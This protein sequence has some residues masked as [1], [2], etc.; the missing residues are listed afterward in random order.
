MF[1]EVYIDEIYTALANGSS[2]TETTG[3]T[4]RLQVRGHNQRNNPDPLARI[5]ALRVAAALGV[6]AG[7]VIA[8]AYCGDPSNDIR[9]FVL[10]QAQAAQEA[11]LPI[12]RRLTEDSDATI[13]TRALGLLRQLVDRQSV[14]L[15][16]RLLDAEHP[17]VRAAAADLL[18][19]I[20]GRSASLNLRRLTTD[21]DK[22]VF[23]AAS[24]ALKRIEG[25]LGRDKPSPWWASNATIKLP[26]P[27]TKLPKDLLARLPTP[28]PEII[29]EEA[30]QP[31]PPVAPKVDFWTTDWAAL[32]TTMPS[33]I[34]ALL[35]LLG[36]VSRE[37]RPTV[38]DALMQSA[39]DSM[40]MHINRA[41]HNNDWVI[42]RGA[43][44]YGAIANRPDLI[45]V[46][47]PLCRHPEAG[48]RAAVAE[49][50]GTTGKKAT[51][52]ALLPM[53]TDADQGVQATAICA[54]ADVC[55]AI[56]RQPYAA[57]Q[58]QGLA[59]ASDPAIRELVA[60]QLKRLTS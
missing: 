8:D 34:P 20:G 2:T 52:A 58:L 39:P 57:S 15:C 35:K 51:I 31:A 40:G 50:I 49:A 13:A 14:A 54:L 46:L 32:P 30:S 37:D 60:F 26:S 23:K 29:V 33:E 43:A 10:D 17:T 18:G 56:G 12:I 48:V 53:L 11:G 6:P 1:S 45:L 55:L 7:L 22:A 28:E 21:P 27:P 16:R 9:T 38:V 36:L 42:A 24:E 41:I 19:H 5:G 47:R 25:E 3:L 59:N 4:K 44:L